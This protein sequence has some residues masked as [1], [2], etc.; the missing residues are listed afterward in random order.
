MFD[1]VFLEL[2]TVNF[3]VTFTKIYGLCACFLPS[4]ALRYR[5]L[6]KLSRPR[7]RNFRST[8]VGF[9]LEYEALPVL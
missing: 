6:V 5:L 4:A 9:R 8:V 2:L 7:A 3:R 1:L